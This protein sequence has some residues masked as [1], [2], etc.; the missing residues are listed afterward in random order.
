MSHQLKTIEHACQSIKRPPPGD[1]WQGPLPPPGDGHDGWQGLWR[2]P[3]PHPWLLARL[4]PAARLPTIP[5]LT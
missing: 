1:G 4:A 5:R 2:W 3:L